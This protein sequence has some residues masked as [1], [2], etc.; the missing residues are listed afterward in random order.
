MDAL[1]SK[2]SNVLRWELT[3]MVWVKYIS[4]KCKLTAM[5]RNSSNVSQWS[6]TYSLLK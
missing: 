6:N 1:L 4:M 2:W 5:M 3:E